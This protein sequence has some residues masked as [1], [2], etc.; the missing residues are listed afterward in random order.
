MTL[1]R[2]RVEL[3]DISPIRCEVVHR[4]PTL[5]EQGRGARVLMKKT[6]RKRGGAGRQPCTAYADATRE[7][8]GRRLSFDSRAPALPDWRCLRFR[9]FQDRAACYHFATQLG[10]TRDNEP[11]RRRGRARVLAPRTLTKCHAV[12]RAGMAMAVWAIHARP[13]AQGTVLMRAAVRIETS[14]H[15]GA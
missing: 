11:V 12:E 2:R 15:A 7:S 8:R 5:F 9:S 14:S 10:G 1:P 4:C 13:G 6:G 3:A